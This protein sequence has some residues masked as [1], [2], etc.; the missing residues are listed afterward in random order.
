MAMDLTCL[1]NHLLIRLLVACVSAL[2]PLI[3]FIAIGWEVVARWKGG[4]ATKA[5]QSE[6]GYLIPLFCLPVLNIIPVKE[7]YRFLGTHHP[8]P[9]D[10]HQTL[11]NALLVPAAMAVFIG[12]RYVTVRNSSGMAR[13][14]MKGVYVGLGIVVVVFAVLLLQ[15]LLHGCDARALWD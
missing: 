14:T 11:Q 15:M 8:V 1:G 7:I 10:N 6:A 13:K 5:A 4:E 12:R 3:I 9:Y 2:V